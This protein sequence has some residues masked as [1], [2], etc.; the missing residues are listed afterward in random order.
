[1]DRLLELIQKKINELSATEID[2]SKRDYLGSFLNSYDAN[3]PTSYCKINNAS[4]LLCLILAT[5]DEF[6]IEDLNRLIKPVE[7]FLNTALYEDENDVTFETYL[8]LLK[9]LNDMGII[10]KYNNRIKEN[11]VTDKK[12][13]ALYKGY[14][15]LRKQIFYY[16]EEEGKKEYFHADV[17]NR[18][19]VLFLTVPN[20]AI[21]SAIPAAD[22]LAWLCKD[23]ID[24]SA[25][26]LR[27]DCVLSTEENGFYFDREYSRILDKATNRLVS[28]IKARM[29]KAGEKSAGITSKYELIR[30]KYH[31]EII[32]AK[33]EAKAVNKKLRKLDNLANFI[34][35]TRNGNITINSEVLEMLFDPKI[36]VCF[37]EYAIAKNLITQ[38]SLEDINKELARNSISKFELIFSEF[39]FSFNAFDSLTK[40]KIVEKHSD[41]DVRKILEFLTTPELK[42]I[43]E[44]RNEFAKILVGSNV[45]SIKFIC[46]LLKRKIIDQKFLINHINI[47]YDERLFE[48]LYK[49]IN[50]LDSIG[51]NLFNLGKSKPE[52]MLLDNND[53]VMET[54]ILG[55][56]GFKLDNKELYNFNVLDDVSLLDTI[57]NFIELGY[58]DIA[59]NNPKYLNEKS[60]NTIKRILIC[61][62][63]GMSPINSSNKFIGAVSTGNGFYV[64]EE[65]YDNYI[66]DY[67]ED[68]LS[69]E[70][71]DVLNNSNRNVIS[72]STKCRTIIKLID[73]LY[74]VD[75]LTYLIAGVKI[76]RKRVKRNLEVLLN[77]ELIDS[78]DIKELTYQA[79]LY[80][81]IPNIESNSL[82]EIY[83]SIM[84]LQIGDE[85]SHLL[86][87]LVKRI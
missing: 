83:N 71:V 40:Q 25:V 45:D 12:D 63:I 55:E 64:K 74:M 5:Y 56:Y 61:E 36:K 4:Y 41:D 17:A 50:Y 24:K 31:Q 60:S 80:N 35:Q 77:S 84:N 20:V 52:I 58:G 9:E 6:S 23:A 26:N 85:E 37:L 69:N 70:C 57:D 33:N 65:D 10:V 54:N 53:I 22:Y 62:L 28:E 19:E 14:K 34:L 73:D 87:R 27:E 30:T 78:F 67:K 29:A 82:D 46:S 11:K 38:T 48:V 79:I 1:M 81:M 68:Y 86:N 18:F 16:A 32:R 59:I 75:H 49:N 15:Q 3:D 43:T 39:G 51:V 76:S 72:N 47:I 13:A 2:L 44:Y 8:Q 66:I 21:F 7:H 42:F